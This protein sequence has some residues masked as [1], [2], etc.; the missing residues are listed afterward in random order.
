MLFMLMLLLQSA[1]AAHAQELHFRSDGTFRIVQFT[2]THI[3]PLK[4][5]SEV[6]F[7]VIEE[8][9]KAENPDL[10]VLTGDVVTGE[11][12]VEG[13]KR[14]TGLL[15][16]LEVPFC[17][18]NGNHDTE[19][20]IAYTDL[21][22]LLT[23]VP[24]SLNRKNDAGVLADLA[25]EVKGAVSGRTEAVLYCIDSHSNSPLPQVGGYAWI[26]FDQIAWY[27][28]CST[29]FTQQ[30]GGNPLPSLAFFHIPLP[31][32]AAAFDA[33]KGPRSGIRLEHECPPD[34]NSGLFTAMLEQGDVMGVFAGHDH[35]ND[36]LAS[37]HGI[38]LGYGRYSGGKTSYIDLQPGARLITLYEGE[39]EF[40]SYIRLKDGRIIDRF[41]NTA[42]PERDL[43]FAVVADLHF[44]MPPESDQYYHVRA[45]NRLENHF[46]WP[47]EV[48][49]F[50]GDTL[51][52]L[53]GVV[54]AGDIF[55]KAHAE[56]HALYKERY[57]KGE[58]D[59]R[60]H[61]D[62]YPGFGN[63]D[64]DPASKDKVENLKGRS[65]NLAY[66]DEVLR[67]KRD[68][69]EILDFDPQ[70]RAYSWNMG[71]VHF[72]QMQTYAGDGHYCEG[73]SLEWLAADLKRYA[74]GNTP[75]VY[76]QHYGFDEWAIKWW[77]ADKR[78]ALFDVLDQY[79]VVGFF[80]GHTHNPSVQSYR[81]YRIF[82]VNNAWPDEDGNGSFAVARIKGDKMAVAT[83]R[84]KDGEGNFEVVS[85]FLT[86][87]PVADSWM[88]RIPGKT[89]M[90]RLSI[91][92]THDSGALKGGKDLQTQDITIE[93]QLLS[94]VRGFDIRLKAMEDNRL[95]VF[96]S[97]Q[98]QD[99]T[100]EEQVLP[101]FVR[102]LEEHP[103]EALVVSLKCEGGSAEAYRRLL[104]ASLKDARYRRFFV[105]D[106]KAGL[107]LDECRGKILFIHRDEVMEDYPGVRTFGWKD[108]VTCEVTLRGSNGKEV[109]ASVQDEYQYRYAGKAPYKTATTLENM[110]R[111]MMEPDKSDRWFI[112]F[113]SA[114][115][116]PVDGPK[117]F[118]DI[119]NPGVAHELQ[120]ID[121][122]C[123][124]VLIDFAGT[125]DGR[126][127]IDALI[128]TNFGK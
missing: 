16:R 32:Y 65:L 44:D 78:E 114:T 14:L 66:M 69:G 12:A 86:E 23:S 79:N 122:P 100:W 117:R 56:T 53:A 112:S 82:Q 28:S 37:H 103:S 73:N 76:I 107:T 20:D 60:L 98:Y 72:V 31:E 84:W 21:A 8:T 95:G 102:F 83:C 4:S 13:W 96:H 6:A 93:Q 15:Q 9:V 92:A 36:Y 64:I 87:Q 3:A 40:T 30:N 17:V 54:I 45:L 57:H 48:P 25:L 46:V 27:R 89:R 128:G 120:G 113:A 67:A 111:A 109:V 39:R 70:S 42:D 119:V 24:N 99:M 59:K 58:G 110:T 11:R 49:C 118:A 90:C 88:K 105:Q 50:A 10:I 19:H 68:A 94:G 81:G 97:V 116:V 126:K 77:P 104:S 123:G 85:P 61:Y 29:R 108:N 43:T 55:D 18:V 125:E 47:E 106:F 1:L 35:D 101:A 115:A 5:G 75:V 41:S 52:R 127:L 71:D 51:T 38:V 34:V 7:Q 26:D 124:M 62:V 80:V 2:D 74:A 22:N 91:P 33:R 63:H 121:R